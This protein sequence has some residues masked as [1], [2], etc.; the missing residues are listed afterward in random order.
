MGRPHLCWGARPVPFRESHSRSRPS[1]PGRHFET[2]SSSPEA[3]TV[4]KML[5]KSVARVVDSTQP[6]LYP[7]NRAKTTGFRHSGQLS[8]YPVYQEL[9]C[10][11]T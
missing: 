1:A 9:I 3:G 4:P 11:W 8:G 6:D 7:F 5:E 10:D 2:G